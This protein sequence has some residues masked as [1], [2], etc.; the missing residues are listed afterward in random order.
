M[1]LEFAGTL[2]VSAIE[3]P[4][5]TLGSNGHRVSACGIA[6]LTS[7]IGWGTGRGYEEA[8]LSM[9]RLTG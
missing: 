9:S 2:R 4:D 5:E 6:R 3:A 1:L 8:K 7:T